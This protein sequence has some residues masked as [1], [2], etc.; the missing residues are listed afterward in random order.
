MEA[1]RSRVLVTCEHCDPRLHVDDAV[2]R[3]E[4]NRRRSATVC[5]NLQQS[6]QFAAGSI[7][8]SH[9]RRRRVSSRLRRCELDPRYRV[10]LPETST[11]DTRTS[12]PHFRAA[13]NSG[14]RA[15]RSGMSG[16]RV[17][18]VE[19]TGRQRRCYSSSTRL[20]VR[21]SRSTDATDDRR[22]SLAA[23]AN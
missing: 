12:P 5:V 11:K 9:S 17:R 8:Q 18:A 3:C 10:V 20:R 15:V 2:G 6:K 1:G 14:W 13:H 7:S 22:A 4:L 19:A 16:R 23:G 21:S